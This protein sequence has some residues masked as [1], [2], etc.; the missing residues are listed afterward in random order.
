MHPN[1]KLGEIKERK[2]LKER[3]RHQQ[4]IKGWIPIH[5]LVSLSEV[6][7]NSS[8]KNMKYNHYLKR[9]VNHSEKKCTRIFDFF[10]DFF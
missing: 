7:P 2:K 1:I 3:D 6:T 5:N 9:G 4:N 10:F 8:E